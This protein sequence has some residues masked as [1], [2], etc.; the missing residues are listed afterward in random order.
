MNDKAKINPLINKEDQE[1][2]S[3]IYLE[4]ISLEKDRLF[5]NT[6]AIT[7]I[8]IEIRLLQKMSRSKS[9]KCIHGSVGIK[10]EKDKHNDKLLLRIMVKL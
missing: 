6:H 4:G 9:Y 10:R 3:L 1:G 5:N 8:S 2:F 7:E